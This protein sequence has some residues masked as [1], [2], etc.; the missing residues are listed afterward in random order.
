MVGGGGVSLRNRLGNSYLPTNAFFRTC[1]FCW[2]F[3]GYSFECLWVAGEGVG[4]CKEGVRF[5]GGLGGMV[6]GVVC[7]AAET[8]IPLL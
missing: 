1:V 3:V 7:V 4:G 8:H 5:S 2:F 6:G